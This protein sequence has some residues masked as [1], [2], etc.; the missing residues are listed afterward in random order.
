MTPTTA[1]PERALDPLPPD[2]LEEIREGRCVA[3]VGAGF[4]A[5][6]GLPSWRD[7]L[8]RI[9]GEVATPG[10]LTY[11]LHRLGSGSSD[12]NEEVAQILERELGRERFERAL[13]RELAVERYPDAM[14]KR[15]NL[16]YNIPFQAVLTT[17]FDTVLPGEIPGRDVYQKV[18]KHQRSVRSLFARAMNEGSTHW[19]TPVVKLHGDITRPGSTVLSRLDYRRRLY[20]DIAYLGFLRSVFLYNT[21]LYLGFSFTDAYI[22][23][24][25]SETLEMLGRR[26]EDRPRSYAV[27][28]DVP[29]VARKHL[30]EVEGIEVLSYDSRAG[31]DFSDFDRILEAIQDHTNP[32][33]HFGRMLADKRILWV[34]Q[35]RRN[36]EPITDVVLPAAAAAAKAP[37]CRVDFAPTVVDAVSRLRRD[38]GYDLVI[39]HWGHYAPGCPTALQ[40]LSHIR[41]S[42]VQVPLIVF[43]SVDYADENKA[44]LLRRGGIGYYH[45]WDGVLRGMEHVF[46]SARDEG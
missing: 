25:R 41:A 10:V 33:A 44:E 1:Q 15:L 18:L 27:I 40:I 13:R 11:A 24:L 12:G 5:P 16:L 19:P 28:N 17:N 8:L 32:L 42:D 38:S 7:L 35:D 46:S 26:P 31:T 37:P 36:V 23:Q 9:T 4:S 43:A 30:L 39:T 14:T 2:L 20:S 29:D 6:A 22:N 3:F 34:D 21:V 45:S